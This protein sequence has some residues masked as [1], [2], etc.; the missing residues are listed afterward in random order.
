SC[1]RRLLPGRDCGRARGIHV[2]LPLPCLVLKGNLR[3]GRLWLWS[4]AV[5]RIRQT[6]AAVRPVQSAPAGMPERRHGD[7]HAAFKRSE[8]QAT[9][10]GG[11]GQRLD[12]AVVAIARAVERNPLHAGRA[13][14][15]GDSAARL[16]GGLGV[17]AALEPFAQVRVGGAGRG[18]HAGAV[19]AEHLGVDMLAGAQHRQARHAEFADV[20]AGRLGATQAGD[21]LVHGLFSTGSGS[22]RIREWRLE[23]GECSNALAVSIPRSRLPVPGRQ[24][25]L[26]SLRMM[27]SSEYFTPLPLYG[28]GGR[29]PRILAATSPTS[30]LS[31]P[32]TTISVWVGVLRVMPSGAVN[33]T[34]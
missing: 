12:T 10:A 30:C 3:L 33:T 14:L 1:R 5:D 26:A 32:A 28:S 13:R 27:V 24:A 2:F 31:A 22:A 18:K 15:L 7:S 20:R 11:V 17:L 16:R 34:G 29:K 8:L 6:E 23:A 4:G 19:G 25:F 9:L 21:F